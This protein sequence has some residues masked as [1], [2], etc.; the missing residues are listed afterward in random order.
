MVRAR[1]KLVGGKKILASG[2]VVIDDTITLRNCKIIN[3]DDQPVFL[4]PSVRKDGGWEQLVDLPDGLRKEVEGA[5]MDAFREALTCGCDF[6]FEFTPKEG[7]SPVVAEVTA[8]HISSGVRLRNIFLTEDREGKF[9][10]VYPGEE[11]PDGRKLPVFTLLGQA[12][13][14][15]ESNLIWEYPGRG[16]RERIPGSFGKEAED[17]RG[18]GA[19]RGGEVGGPDGRDGG[20]AH[21]KP[22]GHRR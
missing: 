11:L 21:R 5:M 22:A 16:I 18:T 19:R 10:V 12:K 9:S 6:E 8:T 2:E 4:L 20:T 1:M 7:G 15:F 13:E 3:I 14:A 17:G